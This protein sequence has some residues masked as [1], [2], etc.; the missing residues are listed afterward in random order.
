[1]FIQLGDVENLKIENKEGYKWV[2]AITLDCVIHDDLFDK[3]KSVKIVI[4]T[5]QLN[6]KIIKEDT[7]KKIN[8]TKSEYFVNR[9]C[10]LRL[11][12]EILASTT[13]YGEVFYEIIENI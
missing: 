12:F 2:K 5:A 7:K 10:T 4:P 6:A 1:M 9:R 13:E 3:D 8:S 11:D